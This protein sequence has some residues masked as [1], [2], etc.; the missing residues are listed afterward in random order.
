MGRLLFSAALGGH[1][2]PLPNKQTASKLSSRSQNTCFS[3]RRVDFNA[4][5]PVQCPFPRFSFLL[6]SHFRL[7]SRLVS[8]SPSNLQSLHSFF[9][10]YLPSSPPPVIFLIFLPTPP[11][12]CLFPPHSDFTEHLS[13]SFPS[14]AHP[15]TPSASNLLA[16]LSAHLPSIR[17]LLLLTLISNAFLF[18]YPPPPYVVWSSLS[19]L[20]PLNSSSSPSVCVL[21]CLFAT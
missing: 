4:V 18:S 13:T 12:H 10:I 11:A 17:V 2:P 3:H 14:F 1:Q 9:L 21:P 8:F 16:A 15:S 20:P 19:F 7:S 6:C 5:L